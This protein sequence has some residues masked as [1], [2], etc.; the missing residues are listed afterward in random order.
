MG[1]FTISLEM[2]NDIIHDI[3]VKGDFFLVGDIGEGIITPLKGTRLTPEDLAAALPDR[4]DD[5]I[6]N[7]KKEDFIRL[8]Y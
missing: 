8:I 5:I 4:L 6:L 3:D 1:D 2:K 7:L